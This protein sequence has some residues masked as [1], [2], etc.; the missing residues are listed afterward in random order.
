MINDIVKEQCRASQRLAGRPIDSRFSQLLGTCRIQV[1]QWPDLRI[2][3]GRGQ[4]DTCY[5]YSS[6][7]FVLAWQKNSAQEN[8]CRMLGMGWVPKIS[9]SIES[10]GRVCGRCE[11]LGLTESSF[12]ARRNLIVS[13]EDTPGNQKR[14]L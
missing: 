6:E 2:A 9:N 8:S 3:C 14:R 1:Q 4:F 10:F 11:K 13:A 7:P 12:I 5:R